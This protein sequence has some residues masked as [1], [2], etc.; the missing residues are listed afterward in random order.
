MHPI[1]VR[2]VN[3]AALFLTT[4]ATLWDWLAFPHMRDTANV[5]VGTR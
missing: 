3:A 4:S 5:E 1:D 2:Q